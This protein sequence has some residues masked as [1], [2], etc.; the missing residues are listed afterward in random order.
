MKG[1]NRGA[2]GHKKIHFQDVVLSEMYSGQGK[3]EQH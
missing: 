3:N 1:V 2:T